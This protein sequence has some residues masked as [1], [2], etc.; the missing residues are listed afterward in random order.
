MES[1]KNSRLRFKKLRDQFSKSYRENS[2]K[3]IAQK[4]FDTP[5]FKKAK[6][7]GLYLNK[8][9]EV[10]TLRVLDE[11]CR[12]N[13]KVAAPKVMNQNKRLRFYLIENG[14]QD[15]H[16]GSYHVLEPNDSC[17]FVPNKEIDLLLVPGI[18]FDKMGYRLGYGKGFYD[19]FLKG[20]ERFCAIG[21]C[22]EKNFISSL[23]HGKKDVP[24]PCVI[25]E[26]RIHH[27][28]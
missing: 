17:K 19:R 25:T 26:K 1:K 7:V 15:F 21:L 18:A 9:S 13:K 12:L 5:E 24:V 2:S 4:L 8:G 16:L 27:A 11:S 14:L 28:R 6:M 3:K 10:N 22:Y 20:A 23:P